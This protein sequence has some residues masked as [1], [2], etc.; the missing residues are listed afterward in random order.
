MVKLCP[1]A[2]QGEVKT[3]KILDKIFLK[4]LSFALVGSRAEYAS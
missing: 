2:G 3:A 1:G 4:G